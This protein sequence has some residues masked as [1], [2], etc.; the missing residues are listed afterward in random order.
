MQIYYLQRFWFF[1]VYNDS[2]LPLTHKYTI[3]FDTPVTVKGQIFLNIIS[4]GVSFDQNVVGAVAAGVK[5]YTF[6][7][8]NGQEQTVDFAGQDPFGSI[9]VKNI[10]SVTWFLTVVKAWA[11]AHGMIYYITE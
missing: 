4:E 7:D 3:H 2:A 6:I 1:N 10:T 9:Y 11:G 8:G 5:A